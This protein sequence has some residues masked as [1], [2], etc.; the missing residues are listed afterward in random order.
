MQKTHIEI[1]KFIGVG[2]LN[3]A[4]DLLVFNALLLLWGTGSY[5]YVAAKAIAF[6]VA[7]TNSYIWNKYWVFAGSKARNSSARAQM[8]F[9]LISI[10]GLLINALT[11]FAIYA[12]GMSMYPVYTYIVY[13]NIGALAGTAVVLAWNYLGYKYLVFGHY[14][15]E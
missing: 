3:T 4:V 7:V 12:I 8:M 13:A 14:R 6:M 11:S 9:F 2:I 15:Y 1:L 10:A 5:M